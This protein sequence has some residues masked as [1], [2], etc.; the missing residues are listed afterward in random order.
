[1][2]LTRQKGWAPGSVQIRSAVL[3]PARA[4]PSAALAGSLRHLYNCANPS[5]EVLAAYPP[6]SAVPRPAISRLSATFPRPTFAPPFSIGS[7]LTYVGISPKNTFR[8]EIMPRNT[9]HASMFPP[10]TPHLTQQQRALAT[11][12]FC[13]FCLHQ[14]FQDLFILLSTK[15]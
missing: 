14:M 10:R 9:L 11:R 1:M 13:L 12:A 6:S 8:A 5:A 3:A 2:T 7:R 4:P 15:F